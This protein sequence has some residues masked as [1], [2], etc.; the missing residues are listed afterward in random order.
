VDAERITELTGLLLIALPIWLNVWFA[1][2]AKRFD[3]PDILRRPTAEILERFRAG[4]ASLVLA[5]W[6]FML[7]GLLFV[8]AAALL[9]QRLEYDDVT[10]STLAFAVA[11]LAGLV[12]MLG[13]LRWVYLVPELARTYLDPKTDEATR[14]A[15]AVTFRAF[16]HYLGVGVGEHL[17]YLLTGAWTFLIGVAALGHDVVPD[18]LAWP[19]LA[20][21]AGLAA[22]SLEFLGRD[23][24]HGRA[25]A[26][27]A[28]PVLYVLWSLWLLAVGVALL[29]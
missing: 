28:V 8:A 1:V 26:G 21:G 23:E 22:C 7:S 4:G 24:E 20:L 13:L 15:T 25:L 6:A 17:G 29:V 19:A 5:W 27:K 16:H 18:W 14:A 11:I 12:Q 10:P 3:Y 2:L 9:S